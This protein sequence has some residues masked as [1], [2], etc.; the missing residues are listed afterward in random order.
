MWP[1]P[2]RGFTDWVTLFRGCLLIEPWLTLFPAPVVLAACVA[3]DWLPFEMV[4]V[5]KALD[6]VTAEVI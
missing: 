3:M 2:V 4:L 1:K 6:G 5:L